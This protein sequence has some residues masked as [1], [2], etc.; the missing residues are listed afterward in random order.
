M[1][2]FPQSMPNLT[3]AL[4]NLYELIKSQGI[5]LYPDD[6]IR[7][8]ISRAVAKEGAR[9]WRIAKEQTSHKIDIVVA[10]AQAALAAVQKGELGRMRTGITED[11]T[12]RIK[13]LDEPRTHSRIQWVTARVDRDGNEIKEGGFGP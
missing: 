7:R 9:G 4:R 3:A 12:G 11:G 10:L 6:E 13:W 8:A 5:S 1:E 2:E